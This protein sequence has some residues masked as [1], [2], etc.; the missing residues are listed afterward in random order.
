MSTAYV[1]ITCQTGCEKA[2][3]EELQKY[4]SVTEIDEVF[5]TYDIVA[6]LQNSNI[7]TLK[8][9][10]TSDIRKIPKIISTLTLMDSENYDK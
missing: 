8:E 2:V 4:E 10:I 9:N 6:K 5:G 1:L 3:I 7:H